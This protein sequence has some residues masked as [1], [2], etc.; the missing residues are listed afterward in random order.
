MIEITSDR[1]RIDVDRV[2]AWLSTAYWSVGIPRDVVEHSIERSLCFSAFVNDVQVGF[3]RA[4]TDGT[5]FAYVCDVIVDD[6][7]RGAG[8]G[9][10]LMASMMTHPEMQ[11]L[12]RIS[13]VTRDAH[14]LYQS[15][16]FAAIAHPDRHMAIVRAN[17][18]RDRT[19]Q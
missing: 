18:Y 14:S 12:R 15:F 17:P 3:A 7:H 16:G 6:A 9:R 19:G 11:G 10:A 4:V 13:L 2:H 8:V 1:S 5:T